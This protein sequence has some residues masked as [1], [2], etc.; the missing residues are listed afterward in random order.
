MKPE[1]DTRKTTIRRNRKKK[2]TIQKYKYHFKQIFDSHIFRHPKWIR[3]FTSNPVPPRY[4]WNIVES[5]VKHHKPSQIIFDPIFYSFDIILSQR[6][7]V[8]NTNTWNTFINIP[9]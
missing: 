5:G 4:N 3:F 7:N 1:D 6:I 2:I 9:K 8:V